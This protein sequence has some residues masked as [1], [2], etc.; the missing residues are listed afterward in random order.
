[1]IK[2][3]FLK[4]FFIPFLGMVIPYA[5][6]LITYHDLSWLQ[7]VLTSL[8]FIGMSWCIWASSQWLHDKIRELF[9]VQ[10]SSFIKI[11]SLCFTNALFGG[12]IAA[13]LILI[14]YSISG[15]NRGVVPFLLGVLLSVLAVIIFTLVYE[16]LY[17]NKERLGDL[18]VVDRLDQEKTKAELSNLKNDLEPHFLFNSLNTL[19]YLI[20]YD[21]KTAHEFNTKLASILKYFLINKDKDTISLKHELDFIDD[22]IYLLRLRFDNKIE[23]RRQT[24]FNGIDQLFILPFALQTTVENAIKH[25]EFTI[26]NPLNIDLELRDGHI[27]VRNKCKPIKERRNSTGVGLQNLSMRYQLICSK[28]IIVQQKFNDF[29]VKIPLIHKN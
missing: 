21:P 5:S 23:L 10:Q 16:I 29:I 22:Y 4:L 8:Y 13:I 3:Q 24:E 14:W 17:L 20:L 1:M 9:D 15:L 7:I 2:D 27:L 18:Q 25:N 19:S 28:N 6:G 11:L 12:A 26:E